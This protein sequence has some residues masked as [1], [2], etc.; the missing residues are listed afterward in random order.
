MS[1]VV[2]CVYNVIMTFFMGI[3][4]I[5][6]SNVIMHCPLILFGRNSETYVTL[7]VI[8]GIK[9]NATVYVT[10]IIMLKL[11]LYDV[12]LRVR[13]RILTHSTNTHARAHTH[14]SMRFACFCMFMVNKHVH[15]T[16]L[17]L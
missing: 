9:V 11:R 15:D 10:M 2:S 12:V 4:S 1:C 14:T 6:T 8:G 5:L 7:E 13:V 16:K 17:G 3:M